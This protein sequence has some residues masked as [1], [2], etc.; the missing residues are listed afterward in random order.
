MTQ[1]KAKT[2]CYGNYRGGVL[3]AGAN[4]RE[5]LNPNIAVTSAGFQKFVGEDKTRPINQIEEWKDFPKIAEYLREHNQRDVITIPGM[6]ETDLVL[7]VDG[8]IKRHL[9]TELYQA[10]PEAK[11]RFYTVL[12]FLRIHDPEIARILQERNHGQIEQYDLD[13][14]VVSTN[15]LIRNL[16]KFNNGKPGNFYSVFSGPI[17]L[18][19]TAKVHEAE[20][21]DLIEIFQRLPYALNK[22]FLGKKE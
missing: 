19:N 15:Q 10:H 3:E 22:Y 13:D 11:A 2:I 12:D 18:D 1:Y 6:L 17:I 7:P 20:K 21:K 9:E 14:A 4:T 5:Y 8:L 16:T